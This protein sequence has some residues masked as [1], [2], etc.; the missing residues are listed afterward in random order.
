MEKIAVSI[1][2]PLLNE[3]KSLPE[4]VE[5]INK[6]CVDNNLSYETLLIDDGSTDDSWDIILRLSEHNKSIKGIRF[7]K[8]MGKAE[9]L[10][11]GFS[12]SSGEIVITM[13]ADLQDFP[14]EIPE[15]VENIKKGADLVSGWK[16]KRKDPLSKNL[17]TKIFNWAVRIG[18]GIKLHDFNCGLK[19][20]RSDVI[21]SIV[22]YGDM[23]RYIPVLAKIDGFKNIKEQKVQHVARKYGKS[24]YGLNRFYNGILDYLTLYFLSKFTKR[25]MHFFGFNGII[26]ISLSMFSALGLGVQKLYSLHISHEKLPLITDNPWFYI[27]LTSFIVGAQLFMVGVLAEFILQNRLKYNA[28]LQFVKEKCNI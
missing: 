16:Q 23:H 12:E 26:I 27:S 19:A 9:A 3:A 17:P 21:K 28:S 14:E 10:N 1:V 8:N 25:P 24:K 11:I 6:V 4:L 22:L 7:R 18:F 5:R 20:Y 13:D 15:L 2:V